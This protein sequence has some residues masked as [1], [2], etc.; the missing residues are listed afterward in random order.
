MMSKSVARRLAVQ[1]NS[2]MPH[3]E[4]WIQKIQDDAEKL[5]E[6]ARQNTK[7]DSKGHA[8]IS[9]DDDW[10]NEDWSEYDTIKPQ[11]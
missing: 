9:K 6:L 4:K 11:D 3:D 7:Y 8:V 5:F 1:R 10:W 2:D